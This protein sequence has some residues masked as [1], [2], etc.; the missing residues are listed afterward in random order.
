MCNTLTGPNGAYA[1]YRT[2]LKFDQIDKK[3]D[4]IINKLDEIIDNQN[5]IAMLISKGNQML[6]RIE[7]QNNYL[8]STLDRI[9]ENTA[10]TEYNT[11]CAANCAIVME[12][13]AVYKALKYY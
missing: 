5:H 12:S 3:L 4:V 1:L 11:Q 10:V 2:D 9:E 6:H 13:I 7:R 8:A